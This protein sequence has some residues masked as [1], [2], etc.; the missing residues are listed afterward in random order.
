MF[1]KLHFIWDLVLKLIK[2]INN[3]RGPRQYWKHLIDYCQFCLNLL[4]YLIRVRSFKDDFVL[5]PTLRVWLHLH[6]QS[7]F[8]LLCLIKISSFFCHFSKQHDI[9]VWFLYAII[10]RWDNKV[11]LLKFFRRL[12]KNSNLWPSEN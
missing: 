4:C 9:K 11:L 5:R 2:Q 3:C 8:Q 7:L 10:T 1:S 6:Q 12:H